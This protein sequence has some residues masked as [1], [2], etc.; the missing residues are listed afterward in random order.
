MK[1]LNFGSCNVDYV[2]SVLSL[3]KVGEA[4]HSDSLGVFAGGKGLVQSIALSKA[5]AKVYHAGLVGGDGDFLIDVLSS[6]GVNVDLVKRVDGASG[7]AI[8][9]RDIDGKN[10][11][12][13]FKGTNGMVDKTFVDFVLDNFNKGDII[14]LQNEISGIDYIIDGAYEKGLLIVLNPSPITFDI[15]EIDLN[16][17][18]YLIVNKKECERFF[19]SDNP[20][21]VFERIKS[22][23]KNLKVVLTLSADGSYYI[24]QNEIL[25]CPAFKVKVVDTSAVGDAFTGYFV[26]EIALGKNPFNAIKTAS[27]ASALTVQKTGSFVSIPSR[28]EVEKAKKELISYPI[29]LRKY[30]QL[31]TL[32]IKYIEENLANANVSDLSKILGY[33]EVYT[34]ALVKRSLGDNFSTV[35]QK[36]RVLIASNL[37]KETDLSISE[38]I[39][40][41]GYE[42]ESFFRKIFKRELGKYPLEYRKQFDK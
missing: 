12:I 31:K 8:I 34:S 3:V 36:K 42:N 2:Y 30:N 40:E 11:I 37:L 13:V 26:S 1:I 23:A 29:S 35:L 20:Q 4:I 38:I 16:K 28:L 10:G 41:V 19:G 14:L 32:V 21:T 25:Y 15:K 5:G 6:N 9:Q 17:I 27:T 39:R 33:S 7:H 18:S 22:S 24:D